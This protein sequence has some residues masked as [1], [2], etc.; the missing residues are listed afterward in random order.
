ML[1]IVIA[2]GIDDG[3]ARTCGAVARV[4]VADVG[5]DRGVAT[6]E[7]VVGGATVTDPAAEADGRGAERC[8]C[9]AAPIAIAPPVMSSNANAVAA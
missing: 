5:V 7:E 2:V 1:G 8:A 6:V 9:A 4:L 3:R